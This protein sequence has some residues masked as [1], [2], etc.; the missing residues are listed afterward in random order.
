M[1]DNIL[2]LAVHETARIAGVEKAGEVLTS[3]TTTHLLW[4]GIIVRVRRRRLGLQK[5]ASVYAQVMPVALA[6]GCTR[7]KVT[8]AQRFKLEVKVLRLSIPGF[9]TN[10]TDGD[11]STS[12]LL[13]IGITAL[14][15]QITNGGNRVM[16]LRQSVECLRQRPASAPAR[17]WRWEGRLFAR[18]I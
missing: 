15:T 11:R 8:C 6:P 4:I 17:S 2:S 13:S 10:C 18:P 7:C 1:G 3:A 16:G 9:R 12:A 14:R 5:R